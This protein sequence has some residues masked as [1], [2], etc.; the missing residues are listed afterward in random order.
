MGHG[1]R[2]RRVVDAFGFFRMLRGFGR[3][4]AAASLLLI[5]PGAATAAPFDY[6]RYQPADLDVLARRKP[7]L[8]LGVDVSPMRSVRFDVTLVAQAAPCPVKVLKWAMRTS[9]IPKEAVESTPISHCIKVESPK[10]RQY[11]IFI[12]D[13]LTDSLAKEVPQSGK[14]TLYAS[15]VYFAQRGPGLV[16]N[17]FSA[18][19][20]TT[21]Q[22]HSGVDFDTS[23]A[24]KKK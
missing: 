14:L 4:S 20:T 12:Q 10:G 21:P 24:T 13:G 7:P 3:L 11:S 22:P 2:E 15:L 16:V 17:E 6:A 9:G 23:A 8:G 18:Q 5:L 19:P 1:I